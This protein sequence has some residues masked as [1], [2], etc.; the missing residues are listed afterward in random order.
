VGA[1]LGLRKVSLALRSWDISVGI[2]TG[3]RLDGPGSIPGRARSFSTAA[4]PAL[5]S[6]PPPHPVGTGGSFPGG[7]AAGA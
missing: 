3:Y 4:R 2:A 5:G 7:K 6:T 1:F